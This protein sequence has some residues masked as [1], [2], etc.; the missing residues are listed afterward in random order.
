MALKSKAP[1]PLPV[2][3]GAGGE[4]YQTVTPFNVSGKAEYCFAVCGGRRYFLKKFSSPTYPSDDSGMDR[5]TI[6]YKRRQADQFVARQSNLYRKVRNSNQAGHIVCVERFFRCGTK[7]Y[8]A[9]PQVDIVPMSIQ[10]IAMQPQET[11]RVLL[12]A[13]ALS[14]RDLHGQGVVHADIKPDNIMIK[15]TNG[16][17]LIAKVIDFDSSFLAEEPPASWEDVEGDQIYLAP[18]TCRAIGGE[19][20]QLDQ[21]LDVFACGLLFHEYW[22]GHLP[23]YPDNF[24]YAHNAVLKGQVLHADATVPRELGQLLDSMMLA[25]P[26]ARPT[27]QQVLDMLEGK[28]GTV[29]EPPPGRT[30]SRLKVKGY[31]QSEPAT[32]GAGGPPPKV[33]ERPTDGA[34][35]APTKGVEEAMP[36]GVW[37]TPTGF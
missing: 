8:A 12:H 21:K 6:A 17:Y 9:S 24:G 32:E 23:R 13:L 2:V 11:K 26:N 37:K 20:V 5:E 30:G 25:D 29:V 36:D 7:I 28:P 33:R 16:A 19:K 27:M 14:M 15:K 34:G 1:P 3:V 22:T 31:P 18:E 4:E 35:K 10:Q